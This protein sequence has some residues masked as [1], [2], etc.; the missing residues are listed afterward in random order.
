MEYVNVKDDEILFERNK[1]N[2]I[3]YFDEFDG[4]THGIS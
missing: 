4:Y 3:A 1:L 2:Q